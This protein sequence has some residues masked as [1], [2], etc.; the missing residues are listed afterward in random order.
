VGEELR[1]LPHTSASASMDNIGHES[2]VKCPLNVVCR[3]C[4][5]QGDSATWITPI[6]WLADCTQPAAH[7][8]DVAFVR[9]ANAVRHGDNVVIG[10]R[11]QHGSERSGSLRYWGDSGSLFGIMCEYP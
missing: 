6:K 7:V 8:Y 2:E 5:L 11:F 3:W 1:A 10:Q 4:S 9:A